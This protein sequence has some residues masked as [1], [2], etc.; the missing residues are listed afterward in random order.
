MGWNDVR[1]HLVAPGWRMA[2]EVSAHQPKA[3]DGSNVQILR[4]ERVG[5]GAR[6]IGIRPVRTWL[7][8]HGFVVQQESAHGDR[9]E[10]ADMEV[11]LGL[12]EGILAEVT[13]SFR[14]T[15]ESPLRLMEWKVLVESFCSAW[16]FSLF[17]TRLGFAVDPNRFVELVVA[18]DVWGEFE[19]RFK[20]PKLRNS[21]CDRTDDL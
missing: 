4:P 14:M 7:E 18:H 11:W 17:D 16:G 1:V 8:E 10:N 15:K 5:D 13:W 12:C 6:E 2:T 21:P 19:R 20:W 9:A 3:F